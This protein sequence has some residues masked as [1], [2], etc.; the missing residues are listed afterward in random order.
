MLTKDLHMQNLD[1]NDEAVE[2]FEEAIELRSD[3]AIA[4]AGKGIVL[5]EIEQK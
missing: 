4:Y 2:C 5:R 3:S 1:E